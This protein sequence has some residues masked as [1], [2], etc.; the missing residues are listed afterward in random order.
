[1]RG[2]VSGDSRLRD[3]ESAVARLAARLDRLETIDWDRRPSFQEPPPVSVP[4]PGV[5]AD[6]RQAAPGWLGLVGRTCIVLGGAFLL[7]A[8][9]QSGQLPVIGGVWLGLAYAGVWLVMAGRVSGP[10]GLVHGIA[11]LLV[12]LPLIVEAALTFRVLSATAASVVLGAVTIA[13]L[14]VAW[15]RSQHT[16]AMLAALGSLAAA[17]ALALGLSAMLPPVLALVLIGLAALWVAY[18]HDWHWLPP[19][20]AAAVDIG[21]LFVAIRASATPARDDPAT[22]VVAHA[23]LILAYLGSFM[24]RVVF[25]ERGVSLFEI[26]QTAAVLGFGL[27][28][29]TMIAHARGMDPGMIAIP[30]LIAGGLMYV[31]TFVRVAPRRGFG[32]DFYYLGMTALALSLVGVSLL[33]DYPVRPIATAIG[34]LLATLIAWRAG[35]P[36]LALQGAIA[37]IVAAA[38]SGLVTFTVI[39]WLT[40]SPPWPP[41]A[42][43]IW[44]V[45]AAAGA[46][47]LVPRAV[48]DDEPAVLVSLARVVLA[49][50]LVSGAGSLIVLGAGA[51]VSGVATSAGAMATIKTVILAAAAVG[52]AVVGRSPRFV[53]FGWLAYGL[54]AAGGVKL[55]VEDFPTSSPATLFVALAALGAALILVPRVS[56]AR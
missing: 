25:H 26:V 30:A 17:G 32:P 49:V 15:R 44:I 51:L 31:Q 20:I 46:A 13:T 53:E 37:A 8:L 40:H 22:A 7:R 4:A 3:L 34:A 41:A 16:L 54:L 56:R 39:V 43:P 11:A 48:H 27:A 52:L 42:M 33:F 14:V 45:L 28:G 2:P 21:M 36:M 50:A 6:A 19:P 47:L 29:A 5:T 23:L 24:I 10:S 38:A 18:A 35:H 12:A 55:L 9:T 1:M